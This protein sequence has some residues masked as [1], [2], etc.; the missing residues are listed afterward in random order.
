MITISIELGLHQLRLHRG[1]NGLAL[2]QAQP[3]GLGS[4]LDHYLCEKFQPTKQ[5]QS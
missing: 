3:N 5:V 4:L 2:G 1:E